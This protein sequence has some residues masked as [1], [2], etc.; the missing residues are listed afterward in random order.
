[1]YPIKPVI[2]SLDVALHIENRVYNVQYLE[3]SQIVVSLTP[4]RYAQSGFK[5]GED[6][7]QSVRLI[8]PWSRNPSLTLY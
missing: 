1:M 8:T 3:T 4:T 6:G 5:P 7:G 2:S